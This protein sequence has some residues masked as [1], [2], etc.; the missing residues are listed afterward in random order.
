MQTQF[1]ERPEGTIA[2]DD[3][4][5]D[6]E[7]VVMWPGVGALR[8]EYRYLAPA[9]VEAGYRVVSADLR[10]HGE[11]SVGWSE[12]TIPAVGEDMLALIKHL[13]A[14][15]A[16]LVGTSF[17][18]GSAVWAAAERPEAVRSLILIGAFVRGQP[19]AEPG[20]ES[21]AGGAAERTL[22]GTG[23]GHVLQDAVSNPATG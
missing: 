20:P 15:P 10:G 16:H 21:G 13:N 8:G 14:G 17:T 23:V 2:Y 5:G 6:G 4:Q 1:F 7:L 9:L 3:S 11:S 22:E 18:P 12:Y 19:A